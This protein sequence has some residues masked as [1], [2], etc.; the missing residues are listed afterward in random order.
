LQSWRLYQECKLIN[1][2][3]KVYHKKNLKNE[4]IEEKVPAGEKPD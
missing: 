2:T 4:K 1:I 3:S